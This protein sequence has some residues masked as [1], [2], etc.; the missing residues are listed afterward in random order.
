MRLAQKSSINK[1][2]GRL[3][4]GHLGGLVMPRALFFALLLTTLGAFDGAKAEDK[5]SSIEQRLFL[6]SYADDNESQRLTRIEKEVF[7]ESFNDSI[8]NRLARIIKAL[9]EQAKTAPVSL[10]KQPSKPTDTTA[11]DTSIPSSSQADAEDDLVSSKQR[12][13]ALTARDDEIAKLMA[14]GVSFW[15]SN[16]KA[17]AI[18]KFQQVI[19][20]DPI[21]AKAYYSLG[22]A[23]EASA[24]IE[25]AKQ[26]YLKASELEPDNS[27]YKQAIKSLAKHTPGRDTPIAEDAQLKALSADA[28]KAYQAG[29]YLSALDLYKQIEQKKPKDP[30]IKFN[31]GTIYLV[32]KK[33]VSALEYYKKAAHLN[34]HD[35][36]YSEAVQ[37]LEANI[38]NDD[39]AR[40]A[41]EA[42]WDKSQHLLGTKD[43]PSASATANSTGNIAD[44][45]T[46]SPKKRRQSSTFDSDPLGFYGL[47]TKETKSG[48][49]VTAITPASRAAQVG[50]INDDLIIAVDGTVVKSVSDLKAIIASKPQGQRF[51]FTVERKRRIGQFIF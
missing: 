34:P 16:N 48:I 51:N 30:L 31:I 1:A 19:R 14:E 4:L 5:F 20:L 6:R 44:T 29:E 3:V 45:R 12:L 13:A 41:A 46:E 27:D 10:I 11:S 7:G 9:P 18:S 23:H 28:S 43:K 33:P 8:E 49:R 17:Q 26:C 25:E 37:K 38:K 15:R 40:L 24:N 21:N 42:S 35:N 22:V 50:L 36:K 32:I 2:T 39:E 47:F